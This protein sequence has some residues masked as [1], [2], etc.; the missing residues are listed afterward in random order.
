MQEGDRTTCQQRSSGAGLVVI[1]QTSGI[2][3]RGTPLA[4]TAVPNL[5]R[6]RRSNR[7]RWLPTRFWIAP[8]A[9]G[10]ILD[11]FAGSGTTLIAAEKADGGATALKSIATTPTSLSAGSMRCTGLKTMHAEF[12]LDFERLTN[13]RFKEK[14]HG[15]KVKNGKRHRAKDR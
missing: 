15:Q 3:P 14:R 10:I 6:T 8:S 1:A 12:K 13:E 7:W 11:V 5:P 9:G 4:R 2:A